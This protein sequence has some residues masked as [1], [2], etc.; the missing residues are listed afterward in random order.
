MLRCGRIASTRPGPVAA[1]NPHAGLL[2]PA[3]Y[4]EPEA[5]LDNAMAAR[6]MKVLLPVKSCLCA[7]SAIFCGCWEGD[8]SGERKGSL[9][10]IGLE[11]VRAL[12]AD[13]I[14]VDEDVIV[15]GAHFLHD[16]GLDSLS[17][18]EVLVRLE[19]E[20]NLSIPESDLVKLTSLDSVMAYLEEAFARARQE[21]SA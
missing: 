14:D 8:G 12:I 3:A 21:T 7:W 17:S 16:L 2:L 10:T 6:I 18:L 4:F 15:P 19:R 11:R 13:A 5:S 1:H 20:F 9:M